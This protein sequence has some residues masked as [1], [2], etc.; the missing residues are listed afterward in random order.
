MEPKASYE[1]LFDPEQL[2][3]QMHLLLGSGLAEVLAVAAQG[4]RSRLR[5][6]ERIWAN[7]A[8]ASLDVRLELIGLEYVDPRTG[9]LV[10]P[11]HEG[12]ADVLALLQLPLDL[13]WVIRTELLD[14]PVFGA[15][16]RAAGHIAIEPEALE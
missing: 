2:T 7:Q 5:E 3:P 10:T 16:L 13:S 11:L 1:D 12:F 6:A 9:Y 4:D 8:I 15:Y 14:L